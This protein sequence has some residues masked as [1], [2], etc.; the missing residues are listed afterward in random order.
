MIDEILDLVLEVKQAHHVVP[1]DHPLHAQLDTL[2]GQLS[3]WTGAL[4]Q[5][6]RALGGSLLEGGITTVAGRHARNLFPTAVDDAAVAGVLAGPL[7]GATDHARTHRAGV[8]DVDAAAAALLDEV[9]T[10][11]SRHVDQLRGVAR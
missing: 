4:A 1:E 11:L 7:Q 2:F 10:G 9:A 3:G 5:R 6:T 8:A